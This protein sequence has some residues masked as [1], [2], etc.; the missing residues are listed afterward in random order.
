[1]CLLYASQDKVDFIFFIKEMLIIYIKNNFK[2]YFLFTISCNL[3]FFIITT[4][5]HFMI[6]SVFF[7][8]N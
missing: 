3:L 5:I 1:M 4:D 7:M 6:F 8:D 2:R